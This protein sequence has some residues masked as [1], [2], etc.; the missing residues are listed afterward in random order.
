[1]TDIDDRP[2]KPIRMTCAHGRLTVAHGHWVHR[3][4]TEVELAHREAFGAPPPP[5]R[6]EVVDGCMTRPSM[7]QWLGG[8]P[9]LPDPAAQPTVVVRRRSRLSSSQDPQR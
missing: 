1:M 6:F 8:V 9:A 7:P 5:R 2:R 3:G 4:D